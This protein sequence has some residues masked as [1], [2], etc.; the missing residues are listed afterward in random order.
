MR[1]QPFAAIR[2]AMFRQILAQEMASINLGACWYRSIA[3]A[4]IQDHRLC[5]PR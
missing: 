3:K 5:R 1:H 2:R 4:G